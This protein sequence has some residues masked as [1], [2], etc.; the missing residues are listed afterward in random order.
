MNVYHLRRGVFL[1]AV[2]LGAYFLLRDSKEEATHATPT[3]APAIRRQLAISVD[4][5][6]LLPN[7]DWPEPLGNEFELFTP[8]ALELRNQRLIQRG[9]A[10]SIAEEVQLTLLRCEELP[11]RLRLEGF[12]KG[13]KDGD[14]LAFLRD[15]DSQELYRVAPGGRV[16]AGK[17]ILRRLL[18]REKGGRSEGVLLWDEPKQREFALYPNQDTPGGDFSVEVEAKLEGK[19]QHF[20][21]KKLGDSFRFSGWTYQWTG[22]DSQLPSI[23]LLRDDGQEIPISGSHQGHAVHQQLPG[24][25]GGKA[26]S[27]R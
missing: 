5:F 6:H 4:T 25:G 3:S 24:M 9:S 18:P 11:Y 21:L 12:S 2:T 14:A 10:R 15:G 27:P 8:P 19:A 7:A 17:F 20:T 13:K 23:L 1:A 22:L 26:Q 16:S